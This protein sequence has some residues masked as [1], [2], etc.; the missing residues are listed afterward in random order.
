M[1]GGE[2]SQQAPRGGNRET[3]LET[4]WA[5]QETDTQKDEGAG[6]EH[7]NGSEA[8]IETFFGL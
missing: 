5:D 1:E 3:C 6:E 4:V 2:E 7:C 8:Q